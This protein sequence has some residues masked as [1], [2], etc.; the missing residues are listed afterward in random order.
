MSDSPT[1]FSA[2]RRKPN[3]WVIAGVAVIHIALFYGLIRALAPAID[4]QLKWPN[5][6]LA[7]GAKCSGI[8]LERSGDSVVI[9]VGVNLVSA[10]DLPDRATAS[11]ADKGAI[12][13]ARE[14]LADVQRLCKDKCPQVASLEKA[15]ANGDTK[16]VVAAEAITPKPVVATVT[17][18]QN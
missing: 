5:D 14:K 2:T 9:G 13:L 4:F 3:P 16:R 12:E 6:V 10:P 15:I 7:D 8:L 11:L 1:P 17:P 18:S